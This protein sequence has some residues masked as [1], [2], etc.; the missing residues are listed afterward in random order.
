[1]LEIQNTTPYQAELVPATDRDGYDRAVVVIKGTFRIV[2][3][4][5]ALPLAEAQAP[6]AWVDEHHGEPATSS[7]R[8]EADTA[9]AKRG[10][11][12]V[13][14][15][16]AY[17]PGGRTR[18]TDVELAVG[19][20]SKTVRVIG[21]RKWYRSLATWKIT[22]PVP[23]E[24]MPLTYERAFGGNDTTHANPEKHAGEPRNPVGT[25]F[26]RSGSKERLTDLP[27]PNLEDPADLIESWRESPAPVGFGFIGRAWAPRLAYAGTYDA[28]WQA[29]RCPLLPEDFDERYF[30]GASAGLVSERFLEGGEPVRLVHADPT[31]E[32]TFSL[33]RVRL[34]VRASVQGEI[35]DA[36]PDL[37]T[38][39]I[40]P[41]AGRVM[42][43]W[44]VA[45]P[46]GRNFLA[47]DAVAIREGA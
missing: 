3:G 11:D 2:H 30:N 27:L 42:L 28:A 31:G 8:I 12:V 26:S 34:A 17:A 35:H 38:V 20:L 36:V 43:T 18:A 21:D 7:V 39:V 6:V 32:L 10:T 47:L 25:G 16:R 22:D 23:F 45:V 15:G 46:S 14:V 29:D 19:P 40:E 5:E 33:P 13:L 1:M 4:A 41:D 37:D 44:R 9:F 24:T